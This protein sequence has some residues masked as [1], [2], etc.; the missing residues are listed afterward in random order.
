M[1]IHEFNLVALQTAICVDASY[2]GFLRCNAWF[3]SVMA[4]LG[5]ALQSPIIAV[6]YLT[7]FAME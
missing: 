6:D 4:S 5:K 3:L 1:S 2:N 7:Q